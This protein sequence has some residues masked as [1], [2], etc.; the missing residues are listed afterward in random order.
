MAIR[1]AAAE[2]SLFHIR[3]SAV[4]GGAFVALGLLILFYTLGLAAGFSAVDPNQ[5]NSLRA[6]GIGVGIWS[7]IASLL[8]LFAGGF[9]AVRLA[10][11]INRGIGALHG[12]VLWGLTTVGAVLL[13][14]MAV[15]SAVR[16]GVRAGSGLVGAASPSAVVDAV[17]GNLDQVLDPINQR[18]RAQGMSTVT[19]PQIRAAIRDVINT[20]VAQGELNQ[21]TLVRSLAQNTDLTRN[22]AQSL[23]QQIQQQWNQA[24]AGVGSTLRQGGIAAAETAGDVMWGLFVA[25]L[26]GLIASVGGA[27]L[28]VS[29][30][31]RW[32]AEHLG[33]VEAPETGVRPVPPGPE[34]PRVTPPESGRH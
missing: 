9:V 15:S 24:T 19:V 18:L 6:I 31:Q 33:M 27:V 3:W 23:A 20:A 8:A 1:A 34:P 26:L 4:F 16:T 25:L 13:V 12:A 10:G 21:Q 5:D 17:T 22:E 29:W 28:G 11:A 14:F 32:E 30:K 2:G 7:I